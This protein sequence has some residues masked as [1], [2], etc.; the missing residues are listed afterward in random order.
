VEREISELR[1]NMDKRKVVAR[2][3]ENVGVHAR[4]KLLP[5]LKTIFLNAKSSSLILQ[6][7]IFPFEKRFKGCNVSGKMIERCKKIFQK[8]IVSTRLI[9][10]AHKKKVPCAG[11]L[12]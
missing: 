6:G 11:D 2:F 12:T 5:Q 7:S 1:V 3:C 4:G 10:L 8:I 9:T